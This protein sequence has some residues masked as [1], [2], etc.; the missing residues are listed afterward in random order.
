MAIEDQLRAADVEPRSVR[1][2]EDDNGRS[3]VIAY[4]SNLA[5]TSDAFS[6][7][8]REISRELARMLTRVDSKP[9]GIIVLTGA[10]DEP[11]NLIYITSRA[12]FLWINGELNDEEFENTWYQQDAT[13]LGQ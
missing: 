13:G 5:A 10:A 7:Q 11:Q 8:E 1:F 6:E 3:L 4:E 2:S 9:D 12:A